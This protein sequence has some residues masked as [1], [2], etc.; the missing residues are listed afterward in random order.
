M[1]DAADIKIPEGGFGP[2]ESISIFQPTGKRIDLRN[3]DILLEDGD[4]LLIFHHDKNGK[5]DGE[6]KIGTHKKDNK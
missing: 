3:A 6:V 5:W 4:K 2:I 1:K